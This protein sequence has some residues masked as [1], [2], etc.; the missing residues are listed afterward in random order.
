MRPQVLRILR[1]VLGHDADEH[2]PFQEL[3]LTSRALIQVRVRLEREL[4]M[5]IPDTAL[6]ENPTAAQL[7]AHIDG[8]LAASKLE[9][10]PA[11]QAHPRAAMPAAD[12]RI[13]VIGMDARFPGAATVEDFWQLLRCGACAVS[14]FGGPGEP[15][16]QP[17]GGVLD[18]ID[19]FDAEFFSM[20]EREAEL[21]DPAHR[22]FLECCYRTLEHAG[23]AAAGD[24]R[25]GVFAGAGM[26]LYGHQFPVSPLS[27]LGVPPDDTPAALQALIG[28]QPDFLATRVAY[29]LGLTGPA[30]GVQ[31][32][33]STS[34]VAVHLAAQSLLMGDS[35][36]AIA[37][38]AALHLPQRS[39]YQHYP[40]FILSPTGCCRAFD[41]AADGTVGGSGVAAV[42]LKPL[43]RAISDR[44]T[45]HAVI[46][47]SAVNNDGARKVGYGAPS[48]TGQEEV[49]RLA[50]RRAGVPAGTISYLE[51]HGTGTEL[52]DPVEFAA[53][54]KV[55]GEAGPP[56]F[57]IL[58]SVKPNVGHLDTCAGMAGL[59]KTVLMLR[60]GEL[61]PSIN[62]ATP[63]PRL[64]LADSPFVLGTENRPWRTGQ[65]FPRRA[66]V[67]ALGVGGT[68]A[69]VVLQEPPPAT[70][71]AA[72]GPN[73]AEMGRCLALPVSARDPDAL[74]L[75]AAQLRD[76]LRGRP[77][78][79]VSDVVASMA[80]GRPHWSCR[81]AVT[82]RTA[83]ELADALDQALRAGQCGEAGQA[84]LRPATRAGD[85][86][87]GGAAT[88]SGGCVTFAFS[89]QG[90]SRPGMARHL[91]DAF[92]VVRETIDECEQ[93]FTVSFEGSL[94]AP[95]IEAAP[96]WPAGT[97]QPAQFAFQVALARLWQA[98]IGEPDFVVGHS[99]GEYAAL[100]VAGGLSVADGVWLT[101]QRDALMRETTAPGGMIAITAP[102]SV[103]R[104]VARD[105]GSE[106]AVVNGADAHVL[107]G[108]EDALS[109]AVRVL[110]DNGLRWRRMAVPHAFHSALM[111]PV[112]DRL[113]QASQRVTFRPLRIPLIS[114][115][116]GHRVQASEVI[117][118]S[119]VCE[120]ARQ[121][122]RFDLALRTLDELGCRDYVEI[123]SRATLSVLGGRELPASHWIT[124]ISSDRDL[125][126]GLAE[127][128]TRGGNV[129]W[130][131]V[132]AGGRR[133]PLPG[134]PLQRRK[135]RPPLLERHGAAPGLPAR[136]V[137]GAEPAVPP[138]RANAVLH[139]T[140]PRDASI[141]GDVGVAGHHPDGRAQPAAPRAA[142]GGQE[143]WWTLADRQL[144]LA[145]RMID[146]FESLAARQMALGG[147][148]ANGDT[149]GE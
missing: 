89:G 55:L 81:L 17:V 146:E 102:S 59:I 149:A 144:R 111:D 121:Q 76:Y 71:L 97:G 13:A 135:L 75:L 78:L 128:Y 88:R 52:G 41:A 119:Y 14:T 47:G 137:S 24:A 142:S 33:C 16:V 46:L 3:G 18:G 11:T 35:D 85:A 32:A 34:L 108:D 116:T 79:P 120:Q 62:L 99:L 103:A 28:T 21:T 107:S 39:G 83:A 130:Q 43:D 73:A 136:F 49:V 37:G 58:G 110:E 122:V 124:G 48:V 70:D 80:L 8:L 7:A 67:T 123:G 9:S 148:R 15:G 4:G 12:R 96:E 26:H 125:P 25:I 133:I 74:T 40:G 64:P 38:A 69:H 51:A 57:C 118:E 1:E 65:G 44:D 68:N 112:L 77:E 63:N 127:H 92:P 100:C 30:V 6:F 106:H 61:V 45:V 50:L 131:V 72:S 109:R 132:A 114:G 113:A 145:A 101:A 31:T 66:G 93:Q 129:N 54:V 60:H 147:D 141:P 82:G 105:S 84:S 23:Y 5:R 126:V 22:M 27:R 95:L 115:L 53:L 117:G 138:I 42:L 98:L 86:H 140:S 36:L 143:S 134:Y 10:H 139:D 91:Y 56:G 2:S 29:R 90:S 19:E 94:L 20:T 87:A 104:Q